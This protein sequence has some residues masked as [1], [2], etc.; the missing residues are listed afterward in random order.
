M[1]VDMRKLIGVAAAL[2]LASPL[3][4]AA[5]QTPG[6]DDQIA[7]AVQVLPEDLRA[8]ATVVAYDPATGARKVLRQGTNFIECQPRDPADGFTRCYNKTLAPRRDLEA[9]LKA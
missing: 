6:V 9:K 1:E 7:Q 2:V 5:A 8:G 4:V 3:V